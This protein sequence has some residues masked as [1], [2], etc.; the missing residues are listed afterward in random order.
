LARTGKPAEWLA[1]T[2]D[3]AIK[4]QLIDNGAAAKAAGVFGV[5]TF[6]VDNTHLVWGQDR[7]E[8]VIRML[9]GWNPIA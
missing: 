3:P 9:A 5:P 8:H 2:Q 7:T 6:V 4:Q 1:R